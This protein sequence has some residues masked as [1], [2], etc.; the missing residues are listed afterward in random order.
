M[1]SP[2]ARLPCKG[3]TSASHTNR[4]QTHLGGA[5]YPSRQCSIRPAPTRVRRPL[6]SR[7]RPTGTGACDGRT[8]DGFVSSFLLTNIP[9]STKVPAA[10]EVTVMHGSLVLVRRLLDCWR[11]FGPG[12]RRIRDLGTTR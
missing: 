11:L 1:A 9:G 12:L 8:T 5:I 6:S 10:E 4:D 7:S 2:A 3:S